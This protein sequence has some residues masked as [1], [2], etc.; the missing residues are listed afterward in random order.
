VVNRLFCGFYPGS[1]SQEFPGDRWVIRWLACV[2]C[3][4]RLDDLFGL[5]ILPEITQGAGFNGREKVVPSQIASQ[6]E[7]TLIWP[8]L[9][10][11]LCGL[12]PIYTGHEQV[13]QDNIRLQSLDK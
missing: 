11:P 13:Q 12:D 4:D 3:T 2:N 1:L 8:V 6:D 9:D 7:N 5:D 10:D